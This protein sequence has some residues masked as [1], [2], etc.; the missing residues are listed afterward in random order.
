MILYQTPLG[1]HLHEVWTEILSSVSIFQDI[2]NLYICDE[3]SCIFTLYQ[4]P[5]D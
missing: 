2:T 5:L 1:I 3:L 4:T